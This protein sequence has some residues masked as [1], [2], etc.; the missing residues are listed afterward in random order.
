MYKIDILL[1]Q[2]RKLF[3]TNDLALL[4]QITNHNTLYTTIKRY[5]K[6]GILIPIH[7]GFYATIPVDKIN[8]VELGISYLHQYAYLST[9][10]VL[11]NHGVIFQKSEYI[12]LVCNV[13]KKFAIGNSKYI[14]RRMNNN[15]L[16]QTIGIINDGEVRAATLER[17]VAD[18]LYF[19][20]RF[21]FDNRQAVD[22][23][24]VKKIQKDIG[25]L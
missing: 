2:G 6:K 1:K 12:T 13:S 9:E 17:A 24:R 23:L 21:H 22:W 18:L 11:F 3:H 4:W 15:Y 7:K 16:F 20:K 10:T 14:V 8:H 25:Y 19:N 5:I